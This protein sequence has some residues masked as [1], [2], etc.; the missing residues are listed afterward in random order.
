M[1]FFVLL[2]ALA[3]CSRGSGEAASNGPLRERVEAARARLAAI[4]H[5]AFAARLEFPPRWRELER[6]LESRERGNGAPGWE[7]LLRRFDQAVLPWLLPLEACLEDARALDLLPG[8]IESAL[9][10][11][12]LADDQPFPARDLYRR[13]FF[14]QAEDTWR[15]LDQ[16]LADPHAGGRPGSPTEA[17]VRAQMRSSREAGEALLRRIL[18]VA[19][20]QTRASLALAALERAVAAVAQ[21]HRREPAPETGEEAEARARAEILLPHLGERL[22]AATRAAAAEQAGPEELAEIAEVA[23]AERRILLAAHTARR[24]RLGSLDP[25]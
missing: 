22:A 9:A 6:D 5:E 3:S 7:E 13:G 24:L 25:P 4:R 12:G 1:R 10:A 15:L 20:P 23:T 2:V 11:I 17:L 14:R 18:S 19:E 16:W 8:R 21:W